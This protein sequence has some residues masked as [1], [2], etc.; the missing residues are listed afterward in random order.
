MTS[1][2]LVAGASFAALLGGCTDSSTGP[3]A[4]AAANVLY[5]LSN[6][7]AANQNSVFGYKRAG[8]GTL[9]A[10]AGS[11]FLTGGTG[12]A[13]A[14]QGLGPDD[15]DLPITVS[16]NHRLLFAVNPGSNT[17]A[18]M[19]IASNGSL[20]PIAGSPF[21]SGGINPVSIG[22]DGD[23]L[24]VVNKAQDP[25]QPTAQLPNYT[26]FSVTSIGALTPIV[27]STVTTVAGASPQIA[28]VSPSKAL[29]FG[30]DFL[31]PT[32]PSR[33]GALRAF[34]IGATG[35]LTA[36]P[37]TPLDI[38]GDPTKRVV[39]GLASHP[40]QNVLYVG[41]VAQDKLGVYSYDG[42][43]GALTFR[44]TANNSGHAICWIVT[45]SSGSALYTANTASN[46][47]SWYNT[48]TPLAPTEAQHLVLKEPGPLYTDGMGMM[49]PTSEDFQLTL[50]PSGKNLYVLSQHTN[51]DFSV[52]NGNILHVLTVAADGSL[53][54]PGTPVHLPVTTR[55]RPWGVVAF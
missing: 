15:V 8:D 9:T 32:T 2:A 46:S 5:V 52:T 3:G 50:D 33:Q 21:S 47:V 16:A 43:S 39:L 30:A 27:G 13:N 44:T 45:N 11:P 18:V 26:G 25:A 34:A 36:A 14:T 42:T 51:P 41:F 24:Y 7:P 19:A 28:L 53:T 22:L 55:T 37:G 29:L 23:K 20:T 6:D 1:L 38:P 17:I 35:T 4:G 10:M 12:V 31:A 48:T 40:T 54:E 49:V